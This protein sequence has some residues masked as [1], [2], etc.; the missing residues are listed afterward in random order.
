MSDEDQQTNNTA[1]V[2]AQEGAS[3]LNGSDRLLHTPVESLTPVE[4]HVSWS[5]LDHIEKVSKKRKAE[6]RDVLL[7]HAQSNG[8]QDAKGS[9]AVPMEL[10]GKVHKSARHS[11]T[12]NANKI[13]ALVKLKDIELSEAGKLKFVPDEGKVEDLIA[14]GRLSLDEVAE[15]YDDK[16][17]YSLR[18]E[19]PDAVV[20][21]IKEGE[22]GKLGKL[23]P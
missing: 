7:E 13:R 23:Q 3:I 11:C 1:L 17:S 10:G 5:V 4:V 16:V 6:F 20:Q 8:K 21:A 14:E 2:P 18:V 9:W 15:C 19:K 22:N 12:L